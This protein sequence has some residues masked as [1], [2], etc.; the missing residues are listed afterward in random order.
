ML[1]I[2]G[3]PY[4]DFVIER[5]DEIRSLQEL[6]EHAKTKLPEWLD[7]RVHAAILDLPQGWLEEH[8]LERTPADGETIWYDPA[9]YDHDEDHEERQ[10]LCMA[11]GACSSSWTLDGLL[12]ACPEP[13]KELYLFCYPTGSNQKL[14]KSD[15]ESWKEQFTAAKKQL[16]RKHVGVTLEDDE[17]GIYLAS[18]DLKGVVNRATLLD[19]DKLTKSVQ[20]AV[21]EFTEAVLPVM[22]AKKSGRH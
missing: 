17:E 4:V 20:Q 5:V 19:P 8:G 22:R 3:D 1:K 18:Y 7:D 21:V 12:S 2:T 6:W 13:S 9:L 10:G 15:I 16:A 14:R 11:Y